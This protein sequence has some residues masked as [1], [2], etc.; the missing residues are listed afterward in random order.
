MFYNRL[1]LTRFKRTIIFSLIISFLSLFS[2]SANASVISTSEL[3]SA[4]QSQQQRAY[5]L[6][7]LDRQEVQEQLVE[8]G[9][10]PDDAKE[11]VAGMTDDEVQT[12]A[13][14]LDELPAGS[15]IVGVLAFVLIVLL[16]TDLLDLTNVYNL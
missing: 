7:M 1:F 13:Q 2:L 5:V 14:N 4:Q 3:L 15:G 11:R 9:V 6:E 16:I 8:L 12:M 10:Q